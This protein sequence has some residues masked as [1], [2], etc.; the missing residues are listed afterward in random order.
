[1]QEQKNTKTHSA[2]YITHTVHSVG[3]NH[4]LITTPSL[5]ELKLSAVYCFCP[6]RCT[7]LG[8][9]ACLVL[10]SPSL[11]LCLPPSYLVKEDKQNL[12][13]DIWSSWTQFGAVQSFSLFFFI[14][15]RREKKWTDTQFVF[16]QMAQVQN[17]ES[18]AL[19]NR[20]KTEEEGRVWR[21]CSTGRERP[22]KRERERCMCL[23]WVHTS[24]SNCLTYLLLLLH[25]TTHM[26]THLLSHTHTT[27]K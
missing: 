19:Q 25:F 22:R 2:T 21:T 10:S 13:T 14:G 15:D 1:M 20:L 6:S 16:C 4:H 27:Q 9:I 5:P 23:Q 18:G 3:C 11:P 24:A 7:C 12:S 17:W 8:N 26:L